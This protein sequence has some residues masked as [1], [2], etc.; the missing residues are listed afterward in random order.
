MLDRHHEARDWGGG[1]GRRRQEMV[2]ERP[3]SSGMGEEEELT[4]RA[5]M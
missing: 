5:H 4:C 1:D 3:H 2:V